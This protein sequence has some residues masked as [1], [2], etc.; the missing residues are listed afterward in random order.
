[1]VT[2]LLFTTN[3]NKPA[4]YWADL[5][6]GF[7]MAADPNYAIAETIAMEVDP[8]KLHAVPNSKPAS[9]AIFQ[10]SSLRAS[11]VPLH[12]PEHNVGYV[13]S[14]EMTSHFHPREHP[15]QPARISRI[16]QTIASANYTQRMK[17]I[18]I[19]PARRE[20]V[21]LIHSEDHWDKVLAIQSMHISQDVCYR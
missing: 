21:L 15:E 1:M 20:E 5:F 3:N 8:E 19:R 10:S 6:I 13:Y 9:T 2:P 16:M 14:S 4:G 11:S 12:F 17:W 7:Q 18:P